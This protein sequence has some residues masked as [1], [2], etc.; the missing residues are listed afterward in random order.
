M[1]GGYE[2]TETRRSLPRTPAEW[3]EIVGG[4]VGLVI[5]AIV[6]L[7]IWSPGGL[8]KAVLSYKYSVKP[9]NIRIDAKPHDCDFMLAPMGDKGCHYDPV[10]E[11]YSIGVLVGGT[12]VPKYY[13]DRFRGIPVTS[14]TVSWVKVTD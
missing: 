11:V 13:Q 12:N 7:M 1:G 3:G 8:Y 2:M 4:L 6:C 5:L 14:I 10:V 9:G